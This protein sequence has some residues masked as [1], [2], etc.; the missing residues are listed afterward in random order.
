MPF[1][2]QMFYTLLITMVIIVGISLSTGQGD[3]NPKAIP[4]LRE[5]FV[6][7]KAFNISAYIMMIVLVVLY[8]VFW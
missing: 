1:L 4:L 2:D 7:G 3:D 8:T 6:T 5:T